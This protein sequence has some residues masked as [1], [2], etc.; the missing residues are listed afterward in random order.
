MLAYSKQKW[1]LVFIMYPRLSHR[2]KWLPVVPIYLDV[3]KKWK[4]KIIRDTR[5][6]PLYFVTSYD[7]FV[8]IKETSPDSNC[9]YFPLSVADIYYGETRKE[10]NIDVVQLGRKNI[11]LHEF[12]L[13][14]SKH[15]SVDYIYLE[16]K[17][18]KSTKGYEVGA[19][20]SR[21]EYM[22]LLSRAK[23][24]LV[25]SPAVD[26]EKD[27]GGYDFITHRFYE[28]AISDCYMIG[29]YTQNKEA[30]LLKIADVCKLV[31]DYDEF[32]ASLDEMLSVSI[33]DNYSNLRKFV[34]ENTTKIRA[35]YMKKIM[36]SEGFG[37]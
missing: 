7:L 8:D 18:Y 34:R 16:G 22:D 29:R 11:K 9:V 24:S 37:F 28:S 33:Y 2:Y 19:L 27:F 13:E 31:N 35:E 36:V 30:E 12:M 26:G 10:K 14:Y 17:S 21:K 1:N 5:C 15:R 25:S 6:L 32:E 3:H 4:H 23:V 20:S